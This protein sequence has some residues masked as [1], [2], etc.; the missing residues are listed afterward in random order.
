MT[1]GM[2]TPDRNSTAHPG[3]VASWSAGP[4]A[5]DCRDLRWRLLARCEGVRMPLR[6][7]M[8]LAHHLEICA[9]CDRNK[10]NVAFLRRCCRLH[11]WLDGF[12]RGALPASAD[13]TC[14]RAALRATTRALFPASRSHS[15]IRI[16]SGNQLPAQPA[17]Q[18]AKEQQRL[19]A[20]V[21]MDDFDLADRL[22]HGSL[23]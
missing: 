11:P 10:D 22:E 21:M 4:G 9:E 3:P 14:L 5:A 2:G 18:P 20:R 1:S 19:G 12:R 15:G 17:N 6:E 8:E 23:K 16:A 13:A 7:A